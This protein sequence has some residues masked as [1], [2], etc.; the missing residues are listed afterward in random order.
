MPAS[1]TDEKAPPSP[2]AKPFASLDASAP[3]T[4]AD[5][6]V[7]PALT[8]SLRDADEALAFLS[9][10]PRAAAIAAEGAAILEDEGARKRLL[11]KIDWTITPL[12]AGTYF[13][14]FLDKNTLSYTSVMGIRKDTGLKGQEYSHV[15]MLFYIGFLATEFPTQYLAQRVSRLG[16]YLGTNIVLWGIVL[17][18]HAATS[19]F[20]GLAVCRTL[21]GVFEAC[22]APILVLIIAMWYRKEEQGTRVS[23]FYVCN[24]VTK[25]FGG[26]VAGTQNNHVKKDQIIEAFS[27]LRVW[28]IFLSVMLSSIPNG[29][30]SN[31]NNILLTTFGYTDQQALILDAP[32]GAIG[33]VFVLGA[34]YLSD[35]WNDRSTV[36]LI[37]IVP[38]ILAAALMYGFVGEDGTPHNKAAL[39]AAS[40]LSGTFGAG[41]MIN[42][43]WNASNIAGHSKKVT[44]NAL[45]LVAFC[46]GNILGTQTFQ[47]KEA[48][49]Y[50]SGK[51]SIMACLSASCLVVVALRM[52]NGRLNKKKEAELAAME[53][54]EREALR[55]KMAFA[56]ETDR[57][58]PFFRYTH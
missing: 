21:L 34:G 27:D 32:N 56:D 8:T 17:C 7:A 36:M 9:N 51:I 14:Q 23:W 5:K 45:T 2:T 3:I 22:V 47:S 40:F 30:L 42:L 24:S 41:F 25:I 49:G 16:L 1:P 33:I 4:I 15:S 52:Y 39:L 44:V 38:T 55:E 26:L 35:R 29:G 43:A 50:D 57:R 19:S 20:A 37:C 6:E 11:R 54:E 48:P 53:P 10:H 12:L 28:L 18:C 13:L 58:N 31:F 46:T